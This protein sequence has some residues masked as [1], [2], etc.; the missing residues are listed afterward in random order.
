VSKS[1]FYDRKRPRKQRLIRAASHKATWWIGKRFPDVVPLLYVVGYPKSGTTWVCQLLAD[2]FQLPF[3]RA[4]LLPIACPAVVHGHE[5]V[6]PHYRKSVYVLR[7]GRDVMTSLWFY[8]MRNIKTRKSYQHA[9]HH[10]EMQR[11]LGA[12]YDADDTASHLPEFIRHAFRH[13]RGAPKN[14]VEYYRDWYDPERLPWI[15][16]LA[17]EDLLTEPVQT[18]KRAIEHV[19]G[20]E[21]DVP[22]IERA[23]EHYS[24]SSG[25]GR[26]PGQEDRLAFVRKGISGDWKNHFTPAAARVFDE[27]GGDMLVKLG[28]EPD[29]RWVERFEHEYRERHELPAGTP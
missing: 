27:L 1:L 15:A 22:R 23:V 29:R 25:T 16:Y 19:T 4:S 11:V 17:Y 12:D 13:P 20:E 7:D 6:L 2:Y 5:T 18:L 3:P 26:E 28:Y 9:A 10:R 21:A 14:R 8:H 24:M